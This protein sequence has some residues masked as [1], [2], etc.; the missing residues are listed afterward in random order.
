MGPTAMLRLTLRTLL[1]WLDDV[2]SPGEIHDI[3]Q[4]V[5]EAP[6]APATDRATP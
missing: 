5:Q 3:G 1:A 2:L 4:Q 6:A